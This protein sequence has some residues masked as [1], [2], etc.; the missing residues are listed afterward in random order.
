MLSVVRVQQ[1]QVEDMENG[2]DTA[3]GEVGGTQDHAQEAL[4]VN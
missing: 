1:D 3:A 2:E 4:K